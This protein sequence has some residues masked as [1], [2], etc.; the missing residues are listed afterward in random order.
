[1]GVGLDEKKAWASFSPTLTENEK[2]G[3]TGWQLTNP[4]TNHEVEG[5]A[6]LTSVNR[7]GTISFCINSPGDS[8]V[9]IDVYR[10]GWYN[11][12]GGREVFGPVTVA[13]IAQPAFTVDPTTNM[14]EC[15]WSVTYTL[16]V[17]YSATDAT[18]W[19]SGVY[20]AKLTGL[21]TTKQSYIMFVVRD[22]ARVSDLLF[23]SSVTTFQAYNTWGGSSL[24]TFNS[25]IIRSDKVSFN[26]PYG[27]NSALPGLAYGIGAAEFLLGG[28]QGYPAGWEYCY[29]Q[30]FES[31]GYDLTYCTD[32][33]THTT[34]NQFQNHKAFI[35]CGH[36]E[37][38]SQEMR[39]NVTA[40][41]TGGTHVAVFSANVCYWQIRME[42]S[43]ITGAA[44][45]TEVCYKYYP[46]DS[47]G[48][49]TQD[50]YYLNGESSQAPLITVRWRDG[51]PSS[52]RV[53]LPE[54]MFLGTMYDYGADNAQ[55][56]WTII[57]PSHWLFNGTGATNGSY[58]YGLVAYECDRAQGA[59]PSNTTILTSSPYTGN[60][61][62][63]TGT[64]NATIYQSPAGAYVFAVGCI[65]WSWGL[66]DWG[67]S[68]GMRPSWKNTWCQQITLN[69][70]NTA[71][72]ASTPKPVN[73]PVAVINGPYFGEAN[74][75]V[76]FDASESSS[77]IGL[78][79]TFA[80]NFGD[81]AVGTGS[82]PTHT[83]A[84]PGT[85]SCIVAVT[86][87]NGTSTNA[88]TSVVIA[89]QGS[90]ADVT[91]DSTFDVTTS[92]VTY[93]YPP[94]G[95]GDGIIPT[96]SP[97]NQF[98]Q[99]FAASP[100]PMTGGVLTTPIN[101]VMTFFQQ[102]T[103]AT[104]EVSQAA[105]YD[106]L[107]F[108]T[109]NFNL[110]LRTTGG[111]WTQVASGTLANQN[112]ATTTLNFKP[113][114]ANQARIEIL[115]SYDTNDYESVGLAEVVFP[116]YVP[117]PLSDPGGP[118]DGY[119]GFAVD[120]D[121]TGSSSPNGAISTY[122]WN[123]GDGT[124]GSGAQPTHAYTAAGTYTVTLTIT[125][126]SGAQASGSTTATIT[127]PGRYASVTASS[128]F[129]V[130]TD[131]VRYYYPPSGV[132]D[133]VIPVPSSS[134]QYDQWF[135]ASPLPMNSSG[136]LNTPVTITMQ[137]WSAT[138]VSSCQI[139]QAA[140]YDNLAFHTQNLE[141]SLQS[142]SGTWTQV[143]TGTLT[144]SNGALTNITFPTQ[145][146]IQAQITITSTYDISDYSSVGLAEVI[147]PSLPVPTVSAGGPYSGMIGQSIQFTGTASSPNGAIQTWS[148]SFGDTTTASVQDPTHSYNVAGSYTA[149]LTVTDVAN[150][151]ATATA[152]VTIGAP[153]PSSLSIS[154]TS[155]AGGVGATGTV[156][157]SFAAPAGGLPVSLSSNSS[158]ATVPS[159][160]TV[161]ANATTA[162]FSIGS[163]AVATNTTA[164]ITAT[165]NGA[166]AT[167]TITVDAPVVSAL[168][169]SPTT[170]VGGTASTGTVTL[171][172]AAPTGGT[173]VSLSSSNTS[174]ATV[175]SSV[176]VA[177]GA[178][179][180]TFTVTTTAVA[181][182][183][184]VTITA[185]ANGSSATASLTVDAPVAS[186][187][188]LNP[189]SVQ[190]GTSSTGTV[191]LGSAA[192]TGG[193]PVSLSSSNTSAATV[194]SSVTVA[195]GAT[196]A[197]FTVSTVGV[198]STA[199]ATITATANGGS[200][201]AT[202]T[203]T[204]AS[205]TGVSIS[206]NSVAGGASSTGTVTLSGPAPSSGAKV[207]LSSS[208]TSAATVP[209]SVTVTSG[210][211]TATFTVTTKAVATT[212]TATITATYGSAKPTAAITVNAPVLSGLSLSPTSVVGGKANSTGTV[213][214]SSAAPS[215]GA[216]VTLSSSNTSA[217]TVPASVT[218]AAGATSATFTATSKAVK[219]N[220]TV[221]ITAT[222]GSGKQT[223]SLTVQ[224]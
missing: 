222:Y 117:K 113:T 123:F 82:Q 14:V 135:A 122:A 205:L 30:F 6:S 110:F 132:G 62:T 180:A 4:A 177:A 25:P 199:T 46:T 31:N 175:P 38:W 33:D 17:G 161:A 18:F 53:P 11:G 88:T 133:Y 85:Y 201:T 42:S 13:G 100:Q 210:A 60:T 167:G 90:Y 75:P 39:N 215:G 34:P 173:P 143:G 77:P 209:A 116:V 96:P 21:T 27:L 97:S 81:G 24:Y 139:Y 63:T 120:F 190:G 112:G 211:T 156:T 176:T 198:T 64:S 168:S 115:S 196:T 140:W 3:T 83:Y 1:M 16:S 129:D 149:T 9:Q 98:D 119:V 94:S 166:S 204:A 19:C 125:D 220:A 58:L 221:T 118:Y 89:T 108:H 12:A 224:T 193:M 23:Q 192:P 102:Q 164:T 159:S 155:V 99:W 91:A 44:N 189:T 152:Q 179:T 144:N 184:S 48:D 114:V 65:Q 79:L 106:N 188:S 195:A 5:Y 49:Y 187:L 134:D 186:T 35:I 194:P 87:S 185:S 181:Q 207:T 47:I 32:V 80:W 136:V 146:A 51:L 52:T 15:P 8:K 41:I 2:P 20:L 191:T 154:P 29:V 158:A 197:T 105:W 138:S 107:G 174:A 165:A 217:A 142:P 7:G 76:Q 208:N 50:P 121:G 86:D 73:P 26:R 36:D 219:T 71:I 72:A 92:G 218:V 93:V 45:R 206:P 109:Q 183:A 10:M 43:P 153:A 61:F 223:A 84:T 150:Q 68:T 178:T 214:L 170:D 200:A 171:G 95:V 124:L 131:G 59:Q 127:V 202:I 212:S 55:G 151:T 111:A 28:D 141:L 157:L 126:V 57:D 203:V 67:V 74:Y 54:E 70:L 172:S 147:F 22:D 130:T 216:K 163:T 69:F 66:S 213:T 103:V 104:V 160:V 137:F 128:D 182:N 145:T 169:V 78:S 101:I 148:W 37:Y 40:A 56:N 162:T